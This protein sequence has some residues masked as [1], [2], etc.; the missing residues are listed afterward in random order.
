[1][2]LW[3]VAFLGFRP[4]ASLLD[5]AVAGAFGV[6][7]AGVVLAMPALAGA[8]AILVVPRLARYRSASASGP[9]NG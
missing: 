3:S 9:R 5:G 1:M 2:A 6:R 4:A 7:A 8:A